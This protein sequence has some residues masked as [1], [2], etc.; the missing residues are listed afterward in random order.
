MIFVDNKLW[1]FYVLYFS[2]KKRDSLSIFSSTESRYYVLFVFTIQYDDA[3]RQL[4]LD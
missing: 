2:I 1:H 3:M 4:H